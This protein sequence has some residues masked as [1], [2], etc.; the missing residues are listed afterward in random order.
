MSQFLS[1]TFLNILTIRIYFP[2]GKTKKQSTYIAK[3]KNC[4]QKNG[5]I[6]GNLEH[7]NILEFLMCFY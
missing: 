7:E 5:Q 3:K 6:M 1:R 4:L 2:L